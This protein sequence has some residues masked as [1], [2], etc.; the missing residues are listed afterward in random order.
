MATEHALEVKLLR[1][2][3]LHDIL[4]SDFVD[5]FLL[6]AVEFEKDIP[7]LKISR[8]DLFDERFV[9]NLMFFVQRYVSAELVREALLQGSIE[10]KICIEASGDLFKA[11]FFSTCDCTEVE[12]I[13]TS[14]IPESVLLEALTYYYLR[15][16]F[17]RTPEEGLLVD[18]QLREAVERVYRENVIK[19][20]NAVR[21]AGKLCTQTGE[22]YDYIGLE[23]PLELGRGRK[24]HPQLITKAI[25]SIVR[26]GKEL[27]NELVAEG[28]KFKKLTLI[29]SETELLASVERAL[30]NLA[31]A[32]KEERVYRNITEWLLK[33]ILEEST[34]ASHTKKE[35]ILSSLSTFFGKLKQ[36]ELFLDHLISRL[37]SSSGDRGNVLFR[38]VEA[39]HAGAKIDYAY[40]IPVIYILLVLH[41]YYIF[42]KLGVDK[43]LWQRTRELLRI[44][45]E[46][47]GIRIQ[48]VGDYVSEHKTLH[49]DTL[50]TASKNIVTGLLS[51]TSPAIDVADEYKPD[52][53]LRLLDIDQN[54]ITIRSRKW[55]TSLGVEFIAV[56]TPSKFVLMYDINGR[57]GRAFDTLN[58]RLEDMLKYV[59]GIK[60]F[61][62]MTQMSVNIAS[63][64]NEITKSVNAMYYEALSVMLPQHEAI[65]RQADKATRSLEKHENFSLKLLILNYAK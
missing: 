29:K 61:S 58:T 50:L 42:D 3:G 35:A 10:C 54:A 30:E 53:D 6:N 26:D 23:I 49:Q 25:I 59:S 62:E 60:K 51:L 28:V 47:L 20:V 41:M 34:V 11:R 5:G 43:Y 56:E 37:S 17:S 48:G 46:R 33:N 4:P 40:L 44:V 57:L 45:Q 63:L 31:K 52:F 15:Q 19:L 2:L 16:R 27:E 21:G 24:Y 12:H 36:K 22:E 39:L 9:R 65:L 18:K 64:I 7:L 55:I 8:K 1:I 32:V 38:L 13:V 14:K